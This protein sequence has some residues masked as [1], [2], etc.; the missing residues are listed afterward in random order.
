MDHCPVSN[1]ILNSCYENLD[2]FTHIIQ[3]SYQVP[4]AA[5][6]SSTP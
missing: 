6:T 2:I 3:G 1:A 5:R 4:L